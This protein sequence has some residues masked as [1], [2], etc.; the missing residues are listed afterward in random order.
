MWNPDAEPMAVTVEEKLIAVLD[1]IRNAARKAGREPSEISLV[2]VTKGVD[3]KKIK[4]AYSS[5]I[6]IFGENYVQETQEKAKKLKRKGTQWHFI[7]HLQ[8]N[9]AKLAVELYDVVHTV[10]NLSL[11]VELNKRARSIGRPTIDVLIQV[12]IAGEKTKSGIDPV[13]AVLLARAIS[14]LEHLRLRGLMAI[15]PQFENPQMS[16]PYFITLRRLAE[17]INK[18]RLPNVVLKDLSIG[19]SN[20]FEV[21]IEEGATLVRVGTAIFGPRAG[22]VV[23]VVAPVSAPV[24]APVKEK[25]SEKAAKKAAPKK[26]APAAPVKK[27]AVVKKVVKKAVAKKTA[28]KKAVSAKKKAVVKKVTKKTAQK[29]AAPV[30]KKV[31]KKAVAKKAAPAKKKAVVKKVV[32]KAVTK[33]AAPVKKKAAKK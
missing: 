2:A 27:K 31:L 23:P 7:G 25:V 30:K 28:P 33:K 3:L 8:K 15:P 12:N 17:R 18:E 16:R 1:R 5:G 32:K 22:A 4:E 26:A 24:S 19:M 10:D 13:G 11:A 20:D 6:R 29:K 21:A 14:K 9:K